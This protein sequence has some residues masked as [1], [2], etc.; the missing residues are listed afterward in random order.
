MVAAIEALAAAEPYPGAEHSEFC[1]WR[2]G[3]HAECDCK[4]S[5]REPT[6]EDVYNGYGR[7]GGIGYAPDD[8]PGSLGENDPRLWF[9]W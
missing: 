5:E 9:A 6:D 3:A 1:A 8:Q 7:E 2:F 4:V